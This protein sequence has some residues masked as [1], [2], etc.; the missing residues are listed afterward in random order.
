MFAQLAVL[1]ATLAAPC[2]P[3]GPLKVYVDVD[4]AVATDT[5]VSAHL[6]LT[7]PASGAKV[8]SLGGRLR[9]DT[10]FAR[11]LD[12]TRPTGSP[13]LANADGAGSV[14][15]AGAGAVRGGVI[16][17]LRLRLTE[18]GVLPR[19]D[20]QLTEMNSPDGTSEVTRAAVAGFVA[21]CVGTK[22]A[23]FDVLPPVSSADPGEPLDLRINGCGFSPTRNTIHV[24]DIVLA[25]IRSTDGGTRIRVVVP[26]EYRAR[27]EAA[28]MQM[29]AGVYDVFVDNGQGK[30]NA[31]R[32]TLR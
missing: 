21:R 16:A 13:F 32:I 7:V 31:R 2:N 19:I 9:V 20:F 12:V 3:T 18:P 17:T 4:R 27:A 28:P 1:A 30:S 29:S 10:S 15:V 23:V 22:P 8:A 5:I 6:C 11:I 24:G 25:N 14:L 26:K